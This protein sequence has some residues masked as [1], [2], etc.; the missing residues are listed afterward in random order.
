MSSSSSRSQSSSPFLLCAL[1]AVAGCTPVTTEPPPAPAPE[2]GPLRAQVSTRPLDLPVG[3]ALGGHLRSRPRTDPGSPWAKQLPASRGLHSEPTA[4]ALVL[5]NGVTSVAFVRLDTCLVSPTLRS[6]VLGLLRDAGLEHELFLHASHTHAGPARFQPPARLG[7]STGTDFVSL[8]MDGYDAEVETRM[9]TAIV[10][11]ITEA[12]G[13]LVPVALGV[14]TVDGSE[15]NHDRRCENDPVYGPGYRDTDFTV[16]RLDEVTATGTRPLAALAHF[17]MHGTM[18]SSDCT[19]ISTEGTGAIERA[20]GDLLGVPVMFVQGGAG[21]VS[22]AGSPLGHSGLQGVERQGRVAGARVAEAFAR[23]TPRAPSAQARLEVKHRG[24]LLTREAI[25]YGDGEFSMGPAIQCGFAGEGTC[26][27]VRADPSDVVCFAI[28]PQRPFRT[29]LTLLRVEGLLFVSLPGEPSTGV[30]RKA[31]AALAPLGA[32]TVLPVGYAQDHYGY[33]LEED[34]WLRG[35]YEP[36]VSPWGWKFGA[37]LLAELGEFVATIDQPQ[38]VPDL[39]PVAPATPRPATDALGEPAIVTEP[40]DAERLTV[41]TFAFEG[42]DPT[43]GTPRVALERESGGAFSPVPASAT[44]VVVNGPEVL[45]RY[46]ATPTFVAEPTATVRRHRWTAQFETLPSTAPGRYRLVASGTTQRAGTARA[47]RLESRVFEVTRS[48]AARLSASRLTDGRLAVEARFPPNP[49][50]DLEGDPVG[51]WRSWDDEA[52][53]RV[54]AR[55]RGGQLGATLRAPD[56]TSTAVSL[57]WSAG[58]ERYVGPALNTPGAWTLEVERGG[59]ADDFG[60]T[61]PAATL[62]VSVP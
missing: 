49:E 4:R 48:T 2:P 45:L 15:F 9:A 39:R 47:Y 59:L 32:E 5:D 25:G 35:G 42:G 23:A 31:R 14:A 12:A 26:G 46:E 28:E 60:N 37:Y 52:D 62:D 13:R 58:D 16:V 51:G 44:R 18:L 38:P 22:P 1:L 41:H 61:S 24:V 30:A 36:T 3:I 33:L 7:S 43:L 40:A 53:P 27:A 57:T 20:A 34:D 55:V 19:F 21:D 10:A 17:A 6:R 54:G 29:A 8:V 11:A 50:Q 56:G